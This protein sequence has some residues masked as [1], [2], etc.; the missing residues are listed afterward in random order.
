MAPTNISFL[1]A[2]DIGTLTGYTP[3]TVT[4]DA[5]DGGGSVTQPLYFSYLPVTGDDML[6]VYGYG[7]GTTYLP[8]LRIYTG[9]ASAP[10]QLDNNHAAI[11]RPDQQDIVTFVAAGQRVFFEFAKT[12]G[13]VNPSPLTVRIARGQ[14]QTIIN[15]DLY[16]NDS[17]PGYPGIVMNPTTAIPKRYSLNYPAGEGQETLQN[18]VIAV[19]DAFTAK[20][21]VLYNVASD[22]F[23]VR[24]TPTMPDAN[25]I[26]GLSTNQIDTFW[27][28]K[29]FG[30]GHSFA[31]PI[32]QDG[33]VGTPLDLGSANIDDAVPQADNSAVYAINGSVVQKITNPG[34]VV[35]TF[36]TVDATFSF[37]NNLLMMTDDTLLVPYQKSAAT[38][39][40]RRFN[41]AGVEQAGSPYSLTGVVGI[42]LERIFAD[43]ADPSF[44]WIWWQ[45]SILNHF[46]KYTVSDGSIAVDISR[47][48]FVEGVSQTA[49]VSADTVY[50]GADF[51]CVPIILRV[52]TMSAT[53]PTRR[54]R[55]G[56]LPSS[57]NN[58]R[59]FMSQM[60]LLME[61][62]VGLLPDA[63]GS[64]A[65]S[66]QGA[67]PQIMM[68]I[69]TD[70]GKTWHAEQWR[71]AGM[72]GQNEVRP[73]WLKPVRAYRNAVYQIVVS[74]PVPWRLISLIGQF[75]EGSS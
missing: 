11:S 63:W 24:N 21:P 41:L 35:T 28:T 9:P 1:T 61:T 14:K 65:N 7:N 59:M 34:G 46:Q 18:G 26:D 13:N 39:Y 53:Y 37:G 17:S 12:G 2:T 20:G 58:Y 33:V 3:Y 29:Q 69:S 62:G 8:A 4:E 60:E 15:H 64:T 23:T 32:T 40:I 66:P 16:I 45:T 10:V 50:S 73:R 68:R 6:E 22:G 30:G 55:Q 43:P 71:S 52:G 47:T 48:K 54:L 56:L 19:I 49:T 70:G 67:N 51:S 31:V 42:T 36:T 74:D 57:E 5:W 38:A 75:S 27:S 25:Y 44:F 72:R